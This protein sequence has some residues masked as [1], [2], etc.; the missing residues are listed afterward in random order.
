MD[1]SINKGSPIHCEVPDSG[2]DARLR[3]LCSHA[4]ALFE[5]QFGRAASVVAAGPGRVNLIGEH[6][7]YNDGFVLP[8]AI[9]RHIVIAA[10]PVISEGQ[11]HG[12][13]GL[14]SRLASEG[15]DEVVELNTQ[16]AMQRG[17]PVW[18]NYVRGVIAGFQARGV[19]VPAFEAMIAADLPMGGGLSSSAALE[20]ATATMLEA[21]T[22]EKLSLIE[23]ALLCQKAE[24]DFALVPCGI[25]DQFA[26]AMGRRD[27]LL[28]LDCRSQQVRHV[29]MSDESIAVLI[30]NSHVKHELN[31]GGYALRR[32]QCNA[33]ATGLGISSLRDA[34]MAMLTAAQSRLDPVIFRRARHVISEISRTVETA[35]AIGRGDWPTVGQR[36]YESHASLRDDFE[37][38]CSELD[39]LVEIARSI[40]NGEAGERFK[41]SV[42]GCRMT[43]GGFGGCVVSLV[44]RERAEEIASVMKEQYAKKTGIEA[45]HFVTQPVEGARLCPLAG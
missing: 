37:V 11:R 2:P 26:S 39:D 32:Q 15:C 14:I 13:D 33:A 43:G 23:K 7:D 42:I 34:T 3:G 40:G 1:S 5:R 19:V 8:M 30:V 28:L 38:S 9:D 22:G 24:H 45:S 12:T 17:E 20:M 44:K 27:H 10:A 25:M 36:M 31:D 6:V 4:T 29:P 18:S 41:G 16:M 35:Q 21:L